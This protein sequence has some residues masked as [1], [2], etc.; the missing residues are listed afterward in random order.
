M[1]GSCVRDWGDQYLL[2]ACTTGESSILGQLPR[3]TEYSPGS[4]PIFPADLDDV[5]F[6]ESSEF[7]YSDDVHTD[8]RIVRLGG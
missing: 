3:H 7:E 8:T 4:D 2:Y 1:C 6:E 5:C